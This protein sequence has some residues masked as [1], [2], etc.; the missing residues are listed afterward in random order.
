[1]QGIDEPALKGL[2]DYLIAQGASGLV[3]CGTTGESATLTHEEHRRVVEITVNHVAGR[4]PVIAGAGSNSTAEAI[5]LVKHAAD[6]GADA[7]LVICPYYNRPMQAGLVAHFTKIAESSALPIIIYNI[8]KRTGVNMDPPTVAELSRVPNIIGIKEASGELNQVME[9]MRLAE[10]GFS[11]LSGDG[12]MTFA[13]CCLGGVGGILADAHIL[14]GEWRRMVEL[15][16]AGKIAEARGIHFRLLPI[17]KALFME[18]NPVP[19]KAAM[20]VLGLCSG[21]VRLPLMPATEKCRAILREEMK[22]LDLA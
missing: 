18:T 20:A 16:A 1:M 13:I 11:V 19:V 3:P 12:N 4:V 5:P 15:I 8:P 7:V 2:L 6:V 21:D 9:I 14:P 22:G 10:P 17:T